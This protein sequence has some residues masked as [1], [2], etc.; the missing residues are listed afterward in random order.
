MKYL[1]VLCAVLGCDNDRP[2]KENAGHEFKVQA[3][4]VYDEATDLCFLMKAPDYYMSAVIL[5]PCSDKVKAVAQKVE[6]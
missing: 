6:R 4:Y 2:G 3:K 1:L 5:V